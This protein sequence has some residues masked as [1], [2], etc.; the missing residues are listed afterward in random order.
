VADGDV[1]VGVRPESLRPARDGMPSLAF[2]VAVVEPLGDEVIVHGLVS[3]ELADV[4][5]ED[6]D[7]A[8]V[9]ANGQQRAEAVACL[10][11][12]ERP[13]EGSVIQLGVEPEEVHLFDAVTG[14]AIR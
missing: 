12:K 3:A 9:A 7:A 10:S 1:F 2:E 11:P 5:H 14:L 4:L 8:M 13:A 6:S